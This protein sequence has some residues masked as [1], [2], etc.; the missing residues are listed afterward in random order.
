MMADVTKK[1]LARRLFPKDGPWGGDPICVFC[2]AS[3][4]DLDLFSFR[5]S[6]DGI[7]YN[8]VDA[9]HTEIGCVC[10]ACDDK[11]TAV[12]GDVLRPCRAV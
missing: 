10:G 6:R 4:E 1:S 3:S 12:L 2:G 5:A 11:I 7:P 8:D 9:D